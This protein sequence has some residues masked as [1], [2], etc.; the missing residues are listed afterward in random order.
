MEEWNSTMAYDAA[1]KST[2]LTQ[3]LHVK[4]EAE[5]SVWKQA[6][7]YRTEVQEGAF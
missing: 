7:P 6:V 5:R 3:D 2:A 1:Q 4:P